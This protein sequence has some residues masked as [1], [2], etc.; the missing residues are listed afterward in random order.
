MMT[1]LKRCSI[2]YLV[3]RNGMETTQGRRL[4][5]HPQLLSPSHLSPPALQEAPTLEENLPFSRTPPLL[6]SAAPV[7]HLLASPC[8]S[9]PILQHPTYSLSHPS[10]VVTKL[11][12]ASIPASYPPQPSIR[13]S[14]NQW[15][16]PIRTSWRPMSL[17]NSVSIHTC[18]ISRTLGGRSKIQTYFKKEFKHM[19][20]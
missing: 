20:L 4:M 15:F 5:S 2:L 3:I 9:R 17:R 6:S 7:A 13:L 8:T 11:P 10:G 19:A 12:W 1:K 16:H 18:E 14:S